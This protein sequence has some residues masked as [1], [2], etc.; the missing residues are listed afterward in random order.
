MTA[1]TT[2]A[3]G[4]AAISV[5]PVLFVG[6]DKDEFLGRDARNDGVPMCGVGWI[7]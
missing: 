7:G 1:G 4:L 5:S 6:V 3:R 2:R